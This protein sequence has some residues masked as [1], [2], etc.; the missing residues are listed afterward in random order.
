LFVRNKAPIG[1]K[2][3]DVPALP[4]PKKSGTILDT[5]PPAVALRSQE[6]RES[7]QL[8][9]FLRF[10]IAPYGSPGRI[11]TPFFPAFYNLVKIIYNSGNYSGLFSLAP[12]SAAE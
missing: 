1:N 3:A 2:I 7:E 6:K 11:E 8:L 10:I 4:F 5:S 9:I 12:P